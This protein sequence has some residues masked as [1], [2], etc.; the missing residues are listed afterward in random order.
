MALVAFDLDNTLGYFFHVGIWADFFSLE[1][2]ENYFNRKI[3]PN[4]SLQPSLRKKIRAAENLFIE[5]ILKS[6]EILK[7][8]L[9]PNLDALI[10]PLIKA[11]PR[12]VCIYSNTWNTFSIHLGK[13]IIEE[14][15]DCNGLFNCVIDAAHPVRNHD[16]KTV[17]DGQP[18][19]TLKVLKDI[20]KNVCGVK[21]T[22]RTSDILFV[23]ERLKKHRLEEEEKH[24]LTY[25]KP[26]VFSPKLT[27]TQRESIFML[28][29]EVLE[30]TGLIEDRQYLE[31]DIFHC[32]KY[33]STKDTRE[34]NNMYQLLEIAERKLRAEGKTGTRFVDD[35]AEIRKCIAEFLAKN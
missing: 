29:I 9:R 3:N 26:T 32:K 12:A 31:S 11:K 6:P 34:I 28:G 7:T 14:I 22:I 5:K 15:Y 27:D 35:S 23:D 21:G 20:F 24:G 10:L 2:I 13:R 1:T 17:E 25:L 8:I 33:T 4:F 30:E 18:I 16:W 19:K